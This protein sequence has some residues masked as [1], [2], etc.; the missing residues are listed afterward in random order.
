MNSVLSL[1]IERCAIHYRDGWLFAKLPLCH[2]LSAHGRNAPICLRLSTTLQVGLPP[3]SQSRISTPLN[4]IA[5]PEAVARNTHHA[6]FSP[7]GSSRPSL[8]AVPLMYQR[9]IGALVAYRD[10]QAATRTGCSLVRNEHPHWKRWQP[11][12]LFCLKHAPAGA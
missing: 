5:L 4:C 1:T 7:V 2:P 8:V 10:R 12:S 11:L 3:C 9:A 6:L